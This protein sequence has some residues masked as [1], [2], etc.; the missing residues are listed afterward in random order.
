MTM[1]L[2]MLIVISAADKAV[3]GLLAQPLSEDLGV[4][5]S[6]IGLAGSLFFLAYTLT[7]PLAG[8]LHKKLGLR[9]ALIL[10]SLV[11]AATFL[12]MVV[13]A[14]FVVLLLSRIALGLGEGPASALVLTGVYSWHP[15]EKRGIGG[16]WVTAA[17]AIAKL[18][19][20]PVLAVMVSAWGWRAALLALCLA[21]MAWCSVWIMTWRPGPYG[22]SPKSRTATLAESAESLKVPWAKIFR[23]PTFLGSSLA[24]MAMYTLISVVLT[25][26][27][28]YFE[29]GLGYSR[30]QAGMMFGI[31]SVAALALLFLLSFCSDKLI[32]R[33]IS[34]RLLRGVLPSVLLVSGG[35][36]MA[37]LPLLKS[38]ALAVAVVSLGYG[39]ILSVQPLINA[40]VSQ[41]LPARQM[42]GGLGVLMG[43]MSIGGL[44]APYVAGRIVDEAPSAAAGYATAFQVFGIVAIVAGIIALITV[45]PARE[46]AAFSAGASTP[47]SA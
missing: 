40:A 18:A 46:T 31:P 47:S 39:L 37:T 45:N 21:G 33:G 30:L 41:I 9:L 6:Q 11:W 44:V 12:P 5:A 38:A 22:E 34:A 14:S 42:S 20:V 32:A 8:L 23:S 25:W 29:V 4:S 3:L 13:S 36:A 28:S 16:A 15:T 24:V 19:I 10:L 2:V 35:V 7:G 17:T 27:P 1:L 26:L 43:L